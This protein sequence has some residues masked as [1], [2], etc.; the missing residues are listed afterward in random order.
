MPRVKRGM[1][2][3]QLARRHLRGAGKRQGFGRNRWSRRWGCSMAAASTTPADES[4]ASMIG[5]MTFDT[6]PTGKRSTGNP[7]AAFDEAR[8]GYVAWSRCSD[9]RRRKGEIKANTNFDRNRRSSPRPDLRE[10]GGVRLS[11]PT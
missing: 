11:Q 8:T 10:A 6:N 2:F 5:P 3:K 4:A 1:R 9:T 7:P